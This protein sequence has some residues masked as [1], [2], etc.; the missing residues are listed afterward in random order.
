MKYC[1]QFLADASFLLMSL[2][3]MSLFLCYAASPEQFWSGAHPAACNAYFIHAPASVVA[4]R[5]AALVRD[6]AIEIPNDED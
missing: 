4:A 6:G 3:V 2:A 5:D 1:L